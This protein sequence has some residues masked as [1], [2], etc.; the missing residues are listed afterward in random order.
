MPSFRN[1]FSACGSLSCALLLI[2]GAKAQVPADPRPAA[3]SVVEPA[4]DHPVPVIAQQRPAELPA[5]DSNAIRMRQLAV[6]ELPGRPGFDATLFANGRLLI[7]HFGD[8]TVDIFDPPK[9]RLIAQVT[10]IQGP[11]GM[12]IDA[13]S[14]LVYIATAGS[15]A[16]TVLNSKTWKVEGSVALKKVPENVAYLPEMKALLVSHPPDH[17]VSLVSAGALGRSASD[18]ASVDVGGRPQEMAW[19]AQKKLAYVCIEDRN[20]IAVISFAGSAPRIER[21]IPLLASQPTAVLFEPASRQLFIAV[22][23]AVM[24]IDADSGS[25]ISRAPAAAGTDSLW[26]DKEGNTLYAAAGDGT[27]A[28][29]RVGASHLNVEHEFR[30]DVRGKSLAYD[31]ASHLLYL[32]GGREGKSKIVI[33]RQNGAIAPDTTESALNK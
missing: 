16:I 27:V 3:M 18:L 19:D 6:L 13:D 26:L 32:T 33:L 20:D 4:T 23:Y 8:N 31:S 28:I 30:A 11:R 21:R 15:P 29:I 10:G 12:A 25:E 22:R 14:G 1:A 7:A 5:A 9:R 24:Q 17:S 2:S